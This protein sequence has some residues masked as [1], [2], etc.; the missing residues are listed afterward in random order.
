MRTRTSLVAAVVA[1]L[2]GGALGAVGP[3]SSAGETARRGTLRTVTVAPGTLAGKVRYADAESPAAKVPVRLW[4]PAEKDFARAS[5]TDG[6]GAF[7]L[8]ALKPGRYLLLVGNRLVVNLRVDQDSKGH[9]SP[10]R[11]VMP[12]GRG[13]FAR[14]DEKEQKAMLARME[15]PE[16]G[17]TDA[18]LG[19]SPEGGGIG[20]GLLET[21][22]VGAGSGLVVVGVA[23]AVDD[24]DDDDVVREVVSPSR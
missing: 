22:A 15:T 7:T 16:P 18:S 21:V 19:P 5:S 3:L 11:V 12:R 6:K 8:P 10:V 14:M 17:V 2:V 4:S 23:E 1:L 9:G 20:K 13:R 24:E